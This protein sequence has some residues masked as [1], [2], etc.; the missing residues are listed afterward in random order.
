MK[1]F[2]CFLLLLSGLT[3]LHCAVPQY[4]A[5]GKNPSELEKRAGRELQYFWQK[6]YGRKLQE[7]PESQT[8]QKSVIFLG[9]TEFAQKN[10]VDHASLGEEE[11]LLKTVDDDLI[12]SGGR[13]AGTLYGVYALLEKLGVEFFA[14]DST[15][16]PKPGKTFPRF[17]EKRKPAFIGR[18]VYDS[19]P[20]PMQRWNNGYSVWASEEVIES[21]RLWWLRSRFNGMT[22][23]RIPPYYVGRIY[24]LCHWPEWHT[25]KLYVNPALFA[26]HPEYFAMD[27]TGK[28]IRPGAPGVRGGDVCMS[29]PEVRKV[30]LE[31]LRKMIKA[32]R[33]KRGPD[34]WSIVYDVTRLDDTPYFCQCQPCRKIADYDGSDTGLYVD[35]INYIAREIRKEYPDIVIRMQGH[36]SHGRKLPNKIIPEKNILFRLCD[37]FS[38]RDPFRPIDKVKDPEAL[39]YFKNWTKFGTPHMKMCWDYWNLG[40]RYFTPPRIETVF[41]AIQPDLKYFLRHGVNALFI[42]AGLDSCKPQNFMMLNYYVAAKLFVDPDLDTEKLAQNFMRHYYGEKAYPVLY[43]YFKIIREG[44]AKDPQKPTSGHVSEWQFA[45]SELMYNMY[46]DFKQAAAETVDPKL[47]QHVKSE[48]ITPIWSVLVRW[49]SYEKKF[50][51]NGLSREALIKECKALV[52]EHIRRYDCEKPEMGDRTFAQAFKL[53]EEYPVVPKA[54]AHVENYNIRIANYGCFNV[55]KSLNCSVVKDPD[56]IQEFV[57]KSASKNPAS[58]GVNKVMPGKHRF[59]TTAFHMSSNNK[60]LN[61]FLKRVPQDE[62]YHWYRVP[63][64]IVLGPKSNFWGHGWGINART[65]L[66]YMLTYGDPRDNTW[67]QIWFRAKFTG[68]AYVKGSTKENAIYVDTVV[69]LRHDNIPVH[70]DEEEKAFQKKFA[71]FMK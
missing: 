23:K 39:A 38:S 40:G 36:E 12:V 29:N 7:I 18:V 54:F 42:E 52:R 16:I 63:G 14:F 65:S 64:K 66:W 24:N 71:R 46:K 32:D 62:K 43:K 57:V 22:C 34:E 20:Y 33:A 19:I 55:P 28:R 3:A 61:L 59:R 50:T 27:A 17:N 11:W 6:I 58:H 68:P 5:V 60:Q 26:K 25:M 13:P 31:S 47:K 35:F 1:R 48:L 41:D 53:V 8:G 9:R 21:Y 45:T 2:S 37:T 51:A 10:K 44:V 56:S 49:P 30:A 67:E 69:A 4:L 15:L 70:F